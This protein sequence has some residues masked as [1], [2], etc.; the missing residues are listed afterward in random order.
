MTLFYDRAADLVRHIYDSRIDGP[1]VLDIASYFPAAERFTAMWPA[2]RDEADAVARRLNTVPRFH[3]I[4]REQTAISDNDRRDWRMLIV[5]AYGREFPRNKA[6]CP[7]LAKIVDETPEVLSA[8]IS[9]L[10]PGKHIPPHRGPFRGVL[11]FYLG[12]SVPRHADGRPA[13]VLKVAGTEYRVGSGDA[14]L[15]DD[16]FTHEVWSESEEVRSVLLLDVWRRDMSMDME[17][18]SKIL[19][20]LVRAGIKIRGAD[21][22]E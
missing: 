8:S 6:A 3:E 4:M 9:F 11:R 19:I 7:V 2:L 13:A 10:A 22:G 21:T 5:K 17:L 18:F 14:L 20:A 12:L 16:T 15:W 1:P